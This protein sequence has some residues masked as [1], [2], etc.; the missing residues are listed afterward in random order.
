[1]HDASK[2]VRPTVTSLASRPPA[3]GNRRTRNN[4]TKGSTASLEGNSI[5]SANQV[6]RWL[7]AN[8]SAP[9]IVHRCKNSTGTSAAVQVHRPSC[10]PRTHRGSLPAGSR[11]Q[12]LTGRNEIVTGS[13]RPREVAI[14]RACHIRTGAFCR[15]AGSRKERVRE[16]HRASPPI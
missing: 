16:I 14:H 5:A 7:R 9:P 8:C 1:M 4:R 13:A 11:R 15:T 12:L 3:N 2:Y 6:Q 10:G